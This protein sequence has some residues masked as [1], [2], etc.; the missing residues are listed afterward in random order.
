[1]EP[2]NCVLGL[3]ITDPSSLNTGSVNQVRFEALF[4]CESLVGGQ[5][6]RSKRT[7]RSKSQFPHS[8]L[9]LDLWNSKY[10]PQK[11]HRQ[12]RSQAPYGCEDYMLFICPCPISPSKGTCDYCAQRFRSYMFWQTSAQEAVNKT[13]RLG[14]MV[15][16]QVAR[17]TRMIF[18]MSPVDNFCLV[19]IAVCRIPVWTVQ[20]Q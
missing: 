11:P 7:L 15:D 6:A 4:L 14:K 5:S 17:S 19:A 1:M 2:K 16:I 20:V 10:L 3:R 18:K 13:L 9:Y 8:S 12:T